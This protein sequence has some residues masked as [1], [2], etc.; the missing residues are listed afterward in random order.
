MNNVIQKCI[1]LCLIVS[2]VSYFES[3]I[4]SQEKRN[5]PEQFE[6][7]KWYDTNI[8]DLNEKEK[9]CFFKFLTIY[10][11]K[12]ENFKFFLSKNKP[13][14]PEATLCLVQHDKVLSYIKKKSQQFP[15]LEKIFEKF[16][17]EIVKP[18]S[19]EPQ[20]GK[21]SPQGP[22]EFKKFGE[23]NM[24]FIGDTLDTMYAFKDYIKHDINKYTVGKK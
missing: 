2:C 10:I 11:E 16:K 7:R 4:S 1:F 21:I 9:K 18:L 5:V 15:Q 3:L 14:M 19:P 23:C 20:C 17:N 24:P 8:E 13:R 22:Q 6:I 12:I